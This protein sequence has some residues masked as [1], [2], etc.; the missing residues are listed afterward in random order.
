MIEGRYSQYLDATGQW[1]SGDLTMVK[2]ELYNI[3]TDLHL[4][5]ITDGVVYPL[6]VGPG[7]GYVLT[8]KLSQTAAANPLAV[9]FIATRDGVLTVGTKVCAYVGS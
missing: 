7:P 3:R 4:S 6:G 2:G 9:V 8:Q 5:G 1:V